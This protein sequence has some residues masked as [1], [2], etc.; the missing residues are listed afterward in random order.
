ML[1]S[2]LSALLRHFRRLAPASAPADAAQING[3]LPPG[4]LLGGLRIERL[5]ARGAMGA[6]Y[7]VIDP[8]TESA[9]AIKTIVL[10]HDGADDGA[11]LREHF[12]R[13]AHTAAQLV[14]P[15]IVRVYGAAEQQGLG[16]IVMELLAGTDLTRY[17]R[18]PRLLPEPLVLSVVARVADALAHAHRQ[19]VLHRDVKPANVMLDLA[20]QQ[21]KLTDFGLARLADS[22]ATRSGV[23]LGSPVYMAPE[24]LGGGASSAGSDL[25]ALG[26]T[27]F[28]LLSARL[29]FEGESMGDLLRAVATQAP[30][31]LAAL[32][33]D[34]PAAVAAPLSAALASVLQR[35]P[36][37]RL[38]D[39]RAWAATL[40]EIAA[41]WPTPASAH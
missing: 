32:R 22:E 25:Y 27:L 4:A 41:A 9:L 39:G 30:L 37:Q 3:V 21:V 40:R 14:H 19:G 28:Q 8:A 33:P 38:A 26:V 5:L 16:Y 31:D 24:L 2:S 12:L 7:L 13:E 11:Q 35:D 10:P 6:L 36:A 23:V 15:D 18:A 29:P 34:L 1:R 20:T 17:T